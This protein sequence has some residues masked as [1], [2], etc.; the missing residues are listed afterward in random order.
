[1][2][3]LQ[4]LIIC[5]WKIAIVVDKQNHFKYVYLIDYVDKY[6]SGRNEA[7]CFEPI[8]YWIRDIVYLL[9]Y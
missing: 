9:N 5:N 7:S 3:G 6:I 4:N 1:M 2:I 8:K